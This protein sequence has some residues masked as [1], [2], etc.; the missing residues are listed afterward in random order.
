MN[1]YRELSRKTDAVNLYLKEFAPKQT[2]SNKKLVEAVNYSVNAGGKRIRPILSLAV[3]EML[4]G[5]EKD[6]MP[7]ACA[8][9]YIHTYSLIHDD[10]P[11]MDNDDLRRGVPTCHTVHGEAIA[12]LAGDALLNYAFEIISN[13][14]AADK[15]IA[16]AVRVISKASGL[17]GMIG[18][19]A[20]DLKGADNIEDLISCYSK[21]TGGLICAAAE[22]GALLSGNK[23]EKIQKEIENYAK[24]LGIAFQIKDDLLDIEG[25]ERHTG[26]RVGHDKLT[27]KKTF[28][29]FLGKEDAAAELEKYTD[30]A[31][32]SL[33]TFGA[34][35]DFLSDL[36]EYLCGRRN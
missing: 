23:D 32:K 34:R 21:K 29:Y 9:E 22:I 15:T 26:K 27:G 13:S 8:L 31:K 24:N 12:L 1:F 5:C 16:E 25:E 6:V 4:G 10:L 30:S 35:A 36:A 11:C 3:C 18:G 14:C 2:G 20:D 28:I 17:Y 33:Q 7:F 19:Q